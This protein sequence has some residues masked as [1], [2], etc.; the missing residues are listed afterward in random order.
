MPPY[1]AYLIYGYIYD[2]LGNIV[3]SAT[4]KVTTSIGTKSYSSNSD[5]M[6]LYDLAEIGYTSGETVSVEVT[7]PYNNEIKTHTFIVDGFWKN[8]NITL[9]LR[10]AGVNAVGYVTRP[11]IHS[12]GNKPI[13]SDNPLPIEIIGQSDTMDLVN[14]P[15]FVYA[16]DSKNRQ[17]TKT[18]TMANGDV[19]IKTWTYTGSQWQPTSESKWVKQE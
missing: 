3:P 8:E 1:I 6:F 14:N 2:S 4:L 7:E 9:I 5:G 18:A 11:I 17:S 12:V 10:T 16:Y 13:T 19:Y 15:S